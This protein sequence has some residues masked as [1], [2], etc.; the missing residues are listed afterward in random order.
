[1][2]RPLSAVVRPLRPSSDSDGSPCTRLSA[3]PKA[4]QHPPRPWERSR[5]SKNSAHGPSSPTNRGARPRAASVESA[6]ARTRAKTRI[7]TEAN[8]ESFRWVRCRSTGIHRPGAAPSL[9]LPQEGHTGSSGW[10]ATEADQPLQTAAT[11]HPGGSHRPLGEGMP[12]RGRAD[13]S[14]QAR[15][16]R[17]KG[18]P[19]APALRPLRAAS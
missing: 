18:R 5:R 19:V 2:R 1:M 14:R 12:G 13:P 11:I 7:A 10:C 17:G 8:S 4:L 9:G 3:I 16:E 15:P 6:A